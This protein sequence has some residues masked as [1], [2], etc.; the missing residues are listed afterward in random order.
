MLEHVTATHQSL[1][2]LLTPK[3]ITPGTSP[4]AATI[5][6]TRGTGSQSTGVQTPPVWTCSIRVHR[7][8]ANDAHV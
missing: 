2:F 7:Y 5:G 3:I 8:F 6:C 1:G 4:N